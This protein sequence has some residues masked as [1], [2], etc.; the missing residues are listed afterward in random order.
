MAISQY[1]VD[2]DAG[3]DTTGTGAIGTPWKTVQHALDNITRDT[4][5]GDQINIKAGTDDTLTATLS[6]ATYGAPGP[7]NELAIR[8]YTSAASDGGIGGIDGDGSYGILVGNTAYTHLVDMHL[9]NV[10]ANSILDLGTYCKI[11]NCEIDNG[12]GTSAVTFSNSSLLL[13]SYIHNFGGYGIQFDGGGRVYGCVFEN[14]IND[15]SRAIFADTYGVTAISNVIIIDGAT[16]G[17][18][19]SERANFVANNT[20]YS[21]SGTGSGIFPL[22]GG[23]GLVIMNNYIE[24]FSGAGGTGI[25]ILSGAQFVYVRN[26]RYYNNTT[27]KSV[28]G[29]TMEDTDNSAVGSSALA[30]PGSGD[31][32]VGTDLKAGAYPSTFKGISTDQFMDI[33]AAQREEPAGGGGGRRARI[34]AHGV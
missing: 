19:V 22:A 34:R 15:F 32:S 21:S 4:T 1:Y 6:L 18:V 13:N 5:N 10:G 11:I 26:N 9:H 29:A 2:P 27:D 24:G 33:G 14:G 23:D 16:H 20:I 25:N 3:N 31:F 8:G 17:I 28:G 12:T 7:G 30:N